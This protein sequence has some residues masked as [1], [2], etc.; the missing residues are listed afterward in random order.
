[1]LPKASR[2]GSSARPRMARSHQVLRS[3]LERPAFLVFGP[4]RFRRVL[5]APP[6]PLWNTGKDGIRLRRLVTDR[7]DVVEAFAKELVERLGT[8]TSH[9]QPEEISH[10]PAGQ[11]VNLGPRLAS[12]AEHVDLTMRELAQERLA[13]LRTRRVA[14]TDEQDPQTFSHADPFRRRA[15]AN[16]NRLGEYMSRPSSDLMFKAFADRT[17]LRILHLLRQREMCVGDLVKILGVPQPKASRHLTYLKRSGLVVSRQE[18]LWRHYALAPMR[19]SLH[20]S[21]LKC[22]DTCFTEVSEMKEDDR[23]A[24]A[25]AKSGRC[26]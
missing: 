11:R 12:G 13:H 1:M 5:E 7:D 9:F 6:N 2:P 19:G 8:L 18:G 14:R 26:C 24:R 15:K 3:S 21:L 23:R 25:L 10:G 4:L 16:Y 20:R 17:R 22:L